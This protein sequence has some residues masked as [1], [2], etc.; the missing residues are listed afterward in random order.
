MPLFDPEFLELTRGLDLD[1]FW[2]ENSACRIFSP[3]K[4]R[5]ALSFSPDDHWLFEFFAVPST[6]RYYQQ[7]PYRDDLHREANALLAEYIG[8]PFFDEDTW[9]TSPRRIE[10]L[11]GSEF[12]YHEGSTPWL[13]PV[14]DDPAAFQRVLDQA[15][16]LIADPAALAQWALPEDF[17]AEW[18][19]RERQGRALMAL[20]SGSRGPP[21]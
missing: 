2:A 1:A 3:E 9:V 4:P 15:E 16:R 10:N 18:A 21:R 12:A 20:G 7:K 19:E 17:R 8:M 11:F 13:M 6:L 5:C 14:T